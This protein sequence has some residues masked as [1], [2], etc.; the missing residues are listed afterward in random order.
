MDFQARMLKGLL[1]GFFITSFLSGPL[2]AQEEG[3]E[4]LSLV[5]TEI[6]LEV[7]YIDKHL[8]TLDISTVEDIL[9]PY[10]PLSISLKGQNVS[11]PYGGG[12]VNWI[13]MKAFHDGEWIYFQFAWADNTRDE[14][15]IKHE[16]HRDAVAILFPLE[17]FSE[18]SIFSPRMGDL[19]KPV[20]I[21]HW[22]AD[23]EEAFKGA[24]SVNQLEAQYPDAALDE[25][26]ERIFQELDRSAGGWGA[27]NLLS[28]PSRESSVESLNA[29][30]FGTLTSQEHQDVR[31]HAVWS[32]GRWTVVMTRKLSTLHVD[33]T[34][35]FPGQK[36]YFSL[37]VWNGSAGDLDGQ[38][39][40]SDRWHPLEIETTTN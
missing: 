18:D 8:E 20:N 27:G 6:P 31:G 23:W 19:D 10:E 34:Q 35:M 3:D 32:R 26:T 36:S 30:K 1:L 2:V 39:S 29:A 38:K 17:E 16:Q 22:K 28:A 7:H 14:K 15:V 5:P 12:S 24:G 11:N 25:Q 13:A 4:G 21:W 33:D 37:A 40:V 9:F